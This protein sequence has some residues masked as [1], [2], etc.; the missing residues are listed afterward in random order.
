MHNEALI[1]IEDLCLAISNKLLSQLV[2]IS[3][4]RST[5]CY[6]LNEIS[7]LNQYVKRNVPLKNGKQKEAYFKIMDQIGFC[8]NE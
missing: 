4:D 8:T 2:M 5:H 3:S 7:T 6:A 1:A